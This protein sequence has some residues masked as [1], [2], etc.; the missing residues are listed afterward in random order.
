MNQ[1]FS[2]LPRD[3]R[4][5]LF[6]LGVIAWVV[7]P[8]V[9]GLPL[10]CSLFC[11][12][13]MFWRAALA[14]QSRP[15]PSRWWLLGLLV[16]FIAATLFT[17]KTILGRE[18]GV[19]LLVLLLALKTL[20][21]H[22]R[23]DAFVVF[24]L[25]FFLM[26]TNFFI[27]QSLLTA[28]AMLIALL[29]L[30]TA[31]VN[32]HMPVGR[33]PLLQA[34]RT[35]TGMALLGAPV[36]VLL[37]VLFPRVAPLWGLPSDAASGRS[38]LSSQMT[39]GN[40]ASLALDDSVAMRIRFDGPRPEQSTLYFRGP[41]LSAF[42]GRTWQVLEAAAQRPSKWPVNLQVQEPAISYQVTLEP[43]QQPWL[44][45]LDATPIAPITPAVP[46]KSA[47]MT[48]ELQWVLDTPVTELLRYQATSYPH[49]SHGPIQ[50]MPGMYDFMALPS[51]FNPRTLQW[52]EELKRQPS[53]AN[54]SAVQWSGLALERLR[55]GGYS[56]TLEPG[57]FGLHSADEFWFDRKAGFCEHMAASFVILMRALHVP[58]R[59]VTGYQGG[60]RNAVDG[61]WTVRQSDAHA[62]A[63]VWQAGQG[64]VRVDPTTAVAPGRT[65]SVQR[66]VA[67]RGI[68]ASAIF[69]SVSPAL[70]LRLRATWEAM[71]NRWNQWVLNYTQA[72]QLN[73]LKNI[74]FNEP[75]W[76][77]LVWVLCGI[78]VA[79][80]LASAAW[81]AWERHRQDPWLRLLTQAG[82]RVQKS[83]IA[84]LPNS[85]PRQMAQQLQAANPQAN[86]TAWQDWFVRL[87]ALRYAPP[88]ASQQ[89]QLKHLLGAMRRELCQLSLPT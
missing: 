56:Y 82:V 55:S 57:L 76:Q 23:R 75:N 72:K 15:L 27:S 45:V 3:T 34:A 20:E 26:L 13:V 70:A 78:V 25:G 87:E 38:G 80:S 84:L 54:Y 71:N 39:V 24:F 43:S 46:G 51:G 9:S 86:L 47:R 63:E 16:V 36:M 6:M 67:P 79:G 33:P 88:T 74:G 18:A 17:Y 28:A 29:G 60:E 83:G 7:M 50:T 59:V 61:L 68:I 2:Q 5:T 52:A 69:G 21:L 32:A 31:L 48:H 30:L 8:Q 81:S 77:D 44:M 10:W 14:W 11:A 65:G 12:A 41:V 64:W 89:T 42:D 62:W 35:A 1:T 22:A 19:T 66:L 37:F 73:L 53:Y 4:D 49:F 40:M 58:A 85:T